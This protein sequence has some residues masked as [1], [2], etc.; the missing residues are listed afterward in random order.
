V[1][2]IGR[3]LQRV[4]EMHRFLDHIGASADGIKHGSRRTDAFGDRHADIF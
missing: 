3:K 2:G 4:Q 1:R